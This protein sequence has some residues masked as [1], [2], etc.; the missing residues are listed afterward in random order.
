MKK[1]VRRDELEVENRWMCVKRRKMGGVSVGRW[2]TGGVCVGRWKTV[3]GAERTRGESSI[4]RVVRF[5]NMTV[6]ECGKLVQKSISIM[7][8]TSP[9]TYHRNLTTTTQ[10]TTTTTTAYHRSLPTQNSP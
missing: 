4:V 2:R 10:P 7:N 1:L 8:S 5:F 9:K 3:R 6:S